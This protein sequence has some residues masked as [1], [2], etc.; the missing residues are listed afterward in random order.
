MTTVTTGRLL[1][2]LLSLGEQPYVILVLSV[3]ETFLHG[4]AARLATSEEYTAGCAL[5]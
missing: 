2:I 1:S 5:Y 4:L 3:A